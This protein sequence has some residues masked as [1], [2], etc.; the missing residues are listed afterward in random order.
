MDEVEQRHG[1]V[2][3]V[4][5]E[6]TD[7]VERNVRPLFPKRRPSGLRLLHPVLTEMPL[8]RFEERH[9]R[10]GWMSFRHSDQRDVIRFAPGELRRFGNGIANALQPF[11]R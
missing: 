10:L 11:G 3:L 8:A 2:S 6:L 4:G 5:L 1:L 7:E 9:N